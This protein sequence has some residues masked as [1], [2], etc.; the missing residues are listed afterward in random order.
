MVTSRRFLG[1][2]NAGRTRLRQGRRTAQGLAHQCRARAG[3]DR[4]DDAREV[5]EAVESAAQIGSTTTGRMAREVG[6]P[7][8][9]AILAFAEQ[10]YADSVDLL[11][12]IR[13]IA[14]RFG[15]S[16]AQR[17][18]LTQ[19][20]IE[21]AVRDGQVGLGSSLL[22]ERT[23]HKPFSPLTGH[24]KAKLELARQDP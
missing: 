21:A 1:T 7:T 4:L 3:A 18:I 23:V 22:H 20:L 19:T 11:Y 14:H 12:P 8:C 10:R 24:F 6:V 15:G 5:L 2:Q 16:N 9:A 17:D 13:S